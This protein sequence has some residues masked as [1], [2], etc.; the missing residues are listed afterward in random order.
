M[1]FFIPEIMTNLCLFLILLLF[2]FLHNAPMPN[3]CFWK[4]ENKIK[5]SDE[6]LS[7]KLSPLPPLEHSYH[8]HLVYQLFLKNLYHINRFILYIFI[9]SLLFSFKYIM[10]SFSWLISLSGPII[11]YQIIV[12][13]FS[14]SLLLKTSLCIWLDQS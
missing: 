7:P 3:V 9:S 14:P 13:W 10:N 12:L 2:L 11:F 1:Y 8:A 4:L 6:L 5:Y